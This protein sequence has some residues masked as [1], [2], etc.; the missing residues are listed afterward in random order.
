MSRGTSRGNTTVGTGSRKGP[1][2][3][4]HDEHLHPHHLQHQE[5]EVIFCHSEDCQEDSANPAALPAN[6]PEAGASETPHPSSLPLAPGACPSSAATPTS[7]PGELKEEKENEIKVRKKEQTEGSKKTGRKSSGSKMTG[8]E[9]LPRHLRYQELQEICKLEENLF[10]K[11]NYLLDPE[12]GAWLE[13]PCPPPPSSSTSGLSGS[14]TGQH[15]QPGM[16]R[17]RGFKE[18]ISWSGAPVVLIA[19]SHIMPARLP[20]QIQRNF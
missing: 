11:V 17:G 8:R 19:V 15:C 9:D 1:S 13:P 12:S 16:A 6:N 3:S 2:R 4:M 10:S 20:R 18:F 7:F 14:L 5:Q